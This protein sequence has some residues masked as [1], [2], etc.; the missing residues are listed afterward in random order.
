M[1]TI[2]VASRREVL[3]T[4][5]FCAAMITER[6]GRERT[7]PA[8]PSG[9]RASRHLG[10]RSDALSESFRCRTPV[11]PRDSTCRSPSRPARGSWDKA[12]HAPFTNLQRCV[13]Q[14]FSPA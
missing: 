13:G 6:Y 2:L 11:P 9:T 7:D 5:V 4:V 10:A 3:D 1:D 14:G 12:E 8:Y